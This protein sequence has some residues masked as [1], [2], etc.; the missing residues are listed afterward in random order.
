MNS[1]TSTGCR[2]QRNRYD[3]F[4]TDLLLLWKYRCQRQ[5]AD[6]CQRN[7]SKQILAHRRWY[8]SFM[9]EDIWFHTF[10]VEWVYP[11]DGNRQTKIYSLRNGQEQPTANGQTTTARHRLQ[12]VL[13]SGKMFISSVHCLVSVSCALPEA[14]EH[15]EVY[16]SEFEAIETAYY[17]VL[18]HRS[19][20]KTNDL[21]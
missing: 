6:D 19:Q 3:F 12:F 14:T 17:C 5:E 11:F 9:E 18:C 1:I 10:G 4:A 16:V 2:L 7:C 8:R 21:K 20:P 15:G 13:C